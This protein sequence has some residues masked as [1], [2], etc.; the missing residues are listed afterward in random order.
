MR[1]EVAAA[2]AGRAEHTK[3]GQGTHADGGSM[4]PSGLDREN[5]GDQSSVRSRQISRGRLAVPRQ[6]QYCQN[7][8]T[9]VHQ[10]PLCGG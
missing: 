7:T 10:T 8:G 4:A 5:G 9:P 2:R 6:W 1:R 3:N